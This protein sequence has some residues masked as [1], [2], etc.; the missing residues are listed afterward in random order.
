MFTTFKTVYCHHLNRERFA[1]VEER[2]T[3][4]RWSLTPLIVDLKAAGKKMGISEE[5]M[6]ETAGQL[7]GWKRTFGRGSRDENDDS[8]DD[9]EVRAITNTRSLLTL[10][11]V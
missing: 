6:D 9:D 4:I 3:G 10:Y 1:L 2:A 11:A 8:T 5:K 7:T